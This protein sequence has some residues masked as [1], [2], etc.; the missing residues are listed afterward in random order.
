[1]YRK[2]S[3][4]W[5][6]GNSQHR[7]EQAEARDQGCRAQG[8]DN[9]SLFCVGLIGVHASQRELTSFVLQVEY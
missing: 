3:R 7:Y 9:E 6:L 2:R 1:M 5:T 8:H 4:P